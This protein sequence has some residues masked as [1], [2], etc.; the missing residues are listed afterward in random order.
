[1]RQQVYELMMDEPDVSQERA[2]EVMQKAYCYF[3]TI[4]SKGLNEGVEAVRSRWADL[5]NEAALKHSRYCND[6]IRGV[7][8][9]SIEKD[10]RDSKAPDEKAD[11]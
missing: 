1:M 4:P 6:M 9:D 11:I 2:K 3:A 10:P 8:Y 5:V 7:Y